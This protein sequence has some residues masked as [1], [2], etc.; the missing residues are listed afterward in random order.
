MSHSITFYSVVFFLWKFVRR[1]RWTI[2]VQI[3][4]CLV[5][6]CKEALFPFFVKRMVNILSISTENNWVVLELYKQ[7]AWLLFIWVAMEVAM[8]TQGRLAARLFPK[9]RGDIR[10]HVFKSMHHNSYKYFN[11]QYPGSIVNKISDLPR[12]C[13]RILEIVLMHGVSIC[14][15]L[16]IGAALLWSVNSIFT[17]IFLCWFAIHISINILFASYCHKHTQSHAKAV[18]SLSGKLVDF[19]KNI[20]TVI[21]F[22]RM[23]YETDLFLKEQNKE[24]I[25]AKQARYSLELVKIIQSVLTVIF[26]FSMFWYLI[27]GW[28][29]ETISIGDFALIPML[30]FSLAGMVWWISADVDTI[31]KEIG[32]VKA[33]LSIIPVEDTFKYNTLESSA[34][35]KS[36]NILF[37]DVIFSHDNSSPLLHG[38]NLSIQHGDKIGIVGL[39]GAGKSTLV[40]LLLKIHTAKSG[41]ILIDNYN[42]DTIDEHSLRKHIMVVHQDPLLF[43]RTILE[44]LQYGNINASMDEVINA[45]K[46]AMCHDFISKLP[47]QYH[48]N[49]GEGGNLLSGGQRQRIA[50]ARA[51][52]KKS[53]ILI[54]DEATSALDAKTEDAIKSNLS[55][56]SF[57]KTI[58][59]IS[60]HLSSLSNMNRIFELKNGSIQEI[61]NVSEYLKNH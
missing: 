17:T 39:S 41:E 7:G 28:I 33:C 51:L 9:F 52:L 31:Y 16:F 57:I 4:L 58:I 1:Q 18:I 13:E 53:P 6:A 37:K 21:T 3:V 40:R 32:I 10:E 59:V 23:Q 27:H 43:H 35:F 36:G 19:V 46:I 54:L 11:H 44:N 15:A 8:R 20:L 42:I 14:A 50:L 60:H 22:D 38:I 29:G 56:C 55:K 49:V 48:N 26:L 12:A 45:S 24:I 30:S 5:W 2:L 25:K 47:N 34:V 61:E